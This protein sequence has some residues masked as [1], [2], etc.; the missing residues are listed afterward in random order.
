MPFPRPRLTVRRLMIAVA[1]VAALLAMA[2]TYQM[3]FS[4]WAYDRW[5]DE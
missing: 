2:R 1:V 4:A 3:N 5:V